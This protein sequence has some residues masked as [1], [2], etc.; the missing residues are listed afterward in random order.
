MNKERGG[1]EETKIGP[2]KRKEK[3][4]PCVCALRWLYFGSIGHLSFVSAHA[5]Y[6]QQTTNIDDDNGLVE[7]TRIFFF[8]N[9][10]SYKRA[11]NNYW[12]KKN[13]RRVRFFPNY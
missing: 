9:P 4:S 8:E 7:S 13:F 10:N 3:K 1:G 2:K 12:K 5:V 6:T 11:K